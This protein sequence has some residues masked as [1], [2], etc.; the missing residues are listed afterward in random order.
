MSDESIS[1]DVAEQTTKNLALL[2]RFLREALDEPTIFERIPEDATVILLPPDD[3]E[4]AEHNANMMIRNLEA[5]KN[6][7]AHRVGVPVPDVP[8]WRSTEML[9]IETR[10][11][12]PHWP[13][14]IA[15]EPGDLVVV[16]DRD[17]DILLVDVFGLRREG[18]GYPVSREVAVRF[19]LE[20]QEIVGY[21]LLGFLASV[22]LRAPHLTSLLRIAEFRAIGSEELGG[23]VPPDVSLPGPETER[24]AAEAL[25]NEFSRLIA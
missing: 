22:V 24:E 23:L 3:P 1:R 21:L 14:N 15:P 5:G 11:L 19:D 7:V 16:Y 25:A 2:G 20:T 6:V 12:K 10:V 18:T 4:L 13:A 8:A 17:R 9:T